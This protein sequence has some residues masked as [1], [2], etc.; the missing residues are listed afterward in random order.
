VIQRYELGTAASARRALAD[1]LPPEVAAAAVEFITGPL[2]ENPRRV[3]KALAD[4]LVGIYS[5][6]L[7]GNWRVLYEIDDNE[8]AIIVLD[9]RARASAYRL[10]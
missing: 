3:G 2:L 9:I 4:E 8:H 1:R 7:G 5:A 10:R 6:R